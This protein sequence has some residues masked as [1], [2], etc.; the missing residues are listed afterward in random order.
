MYS[1]KHQTYSVSDCGLC[2]HLGSVNQKACSLLIAS[3]QGKTVRLP[4]L[5]FWVHAV[6]PNYCLPLL[7]IGNAEKIE[8]CRML[9]AVSVALHA[10]VVVGSECRLYFFLFFYLCAMYLLTFQKYI[11]PENW[12]YKVSSLLQLSAIVFS[13][14]FVLRK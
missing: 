13:F 4:V 14:H 5:K 3:V 10:M 11:V 7:V 12:L 2:D 6:M 9:V 8:I 1:L